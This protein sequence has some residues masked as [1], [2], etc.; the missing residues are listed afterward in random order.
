MDYLVAFELGLR[1]YSKDVHAMGTHALRSRHYWSQVAFWRKRE[2][3]IALGRFLLGRKADYAQWDCFVFRDYQDRQALAKTYEVRHHP[4]SDG[5]DDDH[6]QGKL[7][8]DWDQHAYCPMRRG[9]NLISPVKNEV[10]PVKNVKSPGSAT[11]VT[12]IYDV[13]KGCLVPFE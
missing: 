5:N 6:F 4:L 7:H 10:K 3:Y 12:M 11:K 13:E 1:E 2:A 8:F 9:R